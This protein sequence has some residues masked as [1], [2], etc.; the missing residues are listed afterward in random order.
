MTETLELRFNKDFKSDLIRII[1]A[2]LNGE[3][4][5]KADVIKLFHWVRHQ[6]D[7][8]YGFVPKKYRISG[9]PNLWDIKKI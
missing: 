6:D 7:P 9:G 2:S 5:S 3:H 4:L 1:K 8:A